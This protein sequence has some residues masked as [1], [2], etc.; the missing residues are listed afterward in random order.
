MDHELTLD[1]IRF[2]PL[3]ELMRLTHEGTI[4]VK[5]KSEDEESVLIIQGINAATPKSLPRKKK[6][7]KI[8]VKDGSKPSR[9]PTP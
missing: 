9:Y 6:V 4:F 7:V 3:S 1:Q 8:E 5:E 2:M